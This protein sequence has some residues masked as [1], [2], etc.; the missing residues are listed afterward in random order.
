MCERE[1]WGEG[2]TIGEENGRGD[3]QRDKTGNPAK[4]AGGNL[5][6]GKGMGIRGFFVNSIVE[7]QISWPASVP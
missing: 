1:N 6:Q 3:L 5:L 2:G 4:Y 7:Y